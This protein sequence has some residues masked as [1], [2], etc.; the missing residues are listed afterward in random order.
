MELI[1]ATRMQAAYTMGI[2]PS[3]REH[4]VVAIKGTFAFPERDGEACTLADEQAPLI[5]ADEFFGAPGYSSPRYE[6]DFALTKPRCDILLNATAHAPGGRP[7]PRVP[8]GVKIDGWSKV[9][10]VVG[11]RVWLQRGAT[12]G[13]SAPE[14]FVTKPITYEH[15]F[16]GVDNLD[17]DEEP[18]DSYVANPVG[19][20][21]HRV[22][23]QSRIPGTPLPAT[24]DPADPVRAPWGD[25]RPMGFG[26][27]GRNWVPRYRYAGTYDQ[28]WI[29]NVFPFLPADFDVRYYQAAPEDQQIDHPRGGEEVILANLT[30]Q[31]R[32]RFRLPQLEVPVV[33]FHKRG[34]HE[35]KPAVLDTILIEPD[36]RRAL[37][38]WRASLPL[39]RNMFEITQVVVG[40]MSRAWWR[41]RELGKTYY[42]SLGTHGAGAPQPKRRKHD[43][44]GRDPRLRH[45]DR[46]RAHRRSELRRDPRA[47][48]QLSGD[49]FHRPRR[50][51]DHR[52]RGAAGGALARHRQARSPARRPAAR[53]PGPRARRVAREHPG[54]DVRRRRG[55]AR[56]ARGSR[57]SSV[58]RRLR[59]SRGALSSGFAGDRP[60]PGR[61]RR[62]RLHHASRMIHE[63]GFRQVIVAGVDSYLVAATLRAYDERERLL[64]A[65]NSNGFIPG[66]AGAALLV[67]PRQRWPRAY[68]PFAWAWRSKRRQSRAMSL[69]GEKGWPQPTAKP[70][71]PPGLGLHEI[72]YR[73]ADF[74]GEQYWFKE[75]ALALARVMRDHEGVAGNMAPGRL[76]RRDRR[77]S[78][79]GLAGRRCL[80]APAS[81]TP[82]GRSASPKPRTTTAA[83]SRSCSMEREVA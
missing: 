49:P 78:H 82:P 45:D 57:Q 43:V 32:A 65:E 14:P 79:A 81:A 20:G 53:M 4:L 37:L 54:P 15:A 51:V 62:P 72:D 19:R 28:D 2:E 76:Y 35:Q 17:P 69:C 44:A 50:R 77:C 42:P 66:E 80:P 60:G 52:Q 12:L 21:W 74:S 71:M 34:G 25:Y 83:A 39:K 31:G 23:N 11:D 26:V 3:A 70:S 64:T 73:I 41:A 13:P 1:N 67:G 24:E 40:Q 33:F 29:D 5:M 6:V 63:N 36:Q 59:P 61:R 9:F 38:T 56:P 27:R 16:G 10:D 8:V 18:P 7:S 22:R 58:P 75:A 30:A 46:R 68:R 48:R 55:P 47:P